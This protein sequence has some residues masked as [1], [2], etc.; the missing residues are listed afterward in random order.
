MLGAALAFAIPTATWG[1]IPVQVRGGNASEVEEQSD[2]AALHRASGLHF[3]KS[4]GGM[5]IGKLVVYGAGDVSAVY[6]LS[7]KSSDPWLSFYIYPVGQTIDAEENVVRQSIEQAWT[8]KQIAAPVAIAL[9]NDIRTG[10][11]DVRNAEV[12][13]RSVYAVVRRG[14]WYLKARVTIPHDAGNVGVAAA[15]SAL[16]SLPWSAAGALPRQTAPVP[17]I[18]RD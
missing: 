11:Y 18:G 17:A 8:A 2:G 15:A 12:A 1:A 4:V 14:D 9:P 3:P 10:W 6:Y 13:G 16:Q 5:Q 7:Q